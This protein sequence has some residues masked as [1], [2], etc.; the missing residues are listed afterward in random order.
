[1]KPF[2]ADLR[3]HDLKPFMQRSD[4][5]ATA[6]LL[7]NI[8]LIGF[9]VWLP[10]YSFHPVSLLVSIVILGNRQLGLGILMHDCAHRAL[11]KSPK[12]NDWVGKFLCAAPILAQFEGYRKYHLKHHAK[13]GTVEDP[14]YPNYQHYPV[15]RQSLLRKLGRDLVGL[16]GLKNL[17]FLLMMH[18]GF[19]PYD[20]AYKQTDVVTRPS[21]TEALKNIVKELWPALVFHF[22]LVALLL[23]NGSLWAYSLWWIAYFTTFQLFSR[24]RNAAEH[25]SVPDLLDADP[26]RHARTVYA[27]WLARL[28][29][30]PNHVNYHIEHHWI[31]SAPPYQLPKL[32]AYLKANRLLDSAEVLPSYSQVI[33]SLYQPKPESL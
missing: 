10:I 7:V 27:G 9:A 26:R 33:R 2:Q 6:L 18:A 24:V 31:P 30:A 20:M 1:M 14:D 4:V 12:L 32:H 28:T 25:A 8:A 13:A 29:V 17:Y 3:A 11:F 5:Q 16:T 21:P 23:L 15:K 22:S 19:I